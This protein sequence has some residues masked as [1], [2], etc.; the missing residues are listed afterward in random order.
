MLSGTDGVNQVPGKDDL[1]D[2][3]LACSREQLQASSVYN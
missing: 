1:D 2:V 3:Q